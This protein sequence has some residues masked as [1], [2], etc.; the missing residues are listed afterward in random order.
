MDYCLKF[1]FNFLKEVD[2]Q[3]NSAFLN[4]IVVST[5]Y[6]LTGVVIFR[7]CGKFYLVHSLWLLLWFRENIISVKQ[8][9]VKTR[10][11]FKYFNLNQTQTRRP[12][13]SEIRERQEEDEGGGGGGGLPE[14]LDIS[15]ADVEQW[16]P[17]LFLVTASILAPFFFLLCLMFFVSLP[18]LLPHSVCIPVLSLYLFVMFNLQS[19]IT[20]A[21]ICRLIH[22]IA[23]KNSIWLK[24]YNF[25]SKNINHWLVLHVKKKKKAATLCVRVHA[26]MPF[27]GGLL[28]SLCFV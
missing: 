6:G 27:F 28:M 7:N 23:N 15:P 25:W 11:I 24:M 18:W 8:W 19:T 4:E 3:S 5:V 12:K 21:T 9:L 16:R 2:F 1:G 26:C 17:A 22:W 13:G 14:A 20:Y 10:R